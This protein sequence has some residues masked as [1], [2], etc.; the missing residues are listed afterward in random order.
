MEKYGRLTILSK[1]KKPSGKTN[2]QFCDCL[3][4]CGATRTLRYDSLVEGKTL[5][6]REC[7]KKEF[8]KK[9][10]KH[11]MC[12]TRPHR[13]WLDMKQ[14]C[15]NPKNTA[16][17]YY[18]GKGVTICQ[19]WR[20]SFIAFHGWLVQNGYTDKMTIDRVNPSGPYCPEN[21]RLLTQSENTI[22]AHLGKKH[23]RRSATYGKRP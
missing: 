10:V 21:C 6:C 3:C 19:E 1:Y 2:R 12:K 5:M 18:G 17:L 14:R 16:Y 7:A 8:S 23:I 20:S 9:T 4:D 15:Y 13:I 22:L 11:G